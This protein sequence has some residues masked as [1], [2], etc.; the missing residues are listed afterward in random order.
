M[1]PHGLPC[2]SA[3]TGV[4]QRY[5]VFLLLTVRAVLEGEAVEFSDRTSIHQC[6]WPCP[7]RL[8][9]PKHV[10]NALHYNSE[11]LVSI[12]IY[13]LSPDPI[14]SGTKY[15]IIIIIIWRKDLR[16]LYLAKN[17]L[18]VLCYS[19]L[20]KKCWKLVLMAC[21]EVLG[22]SMSLQCSMLLLTSKAGRVTIHFW[23][24]G[25]ECRKYAYVL[26]KMKITNCF[27]A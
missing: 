11:T 25:L 13:S 9:F 7:A 5:R 27:G 24:L 15:S 19:E 10:N 14:S 16:N 1:P 23:S 3:G 18:K 4:D 26:D 17:I 6:V 21:F 22:P 2:F 12:F 20:V 8:I